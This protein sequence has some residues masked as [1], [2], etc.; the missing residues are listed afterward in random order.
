VSSP[1]RLVALSEL[2]VLQPAAADQPP[3]A[4][5]QADHSFAEAAAPAPTPEPEPETAAGA[6]DVCFSSPAGN[7]AAS[8]PNAFLGFFQF[9]FLSS[10]SFLGLTISCVPVSPSCSISRAVGRWLGCRRGRGSVVSVEVRAPFG[11]YCPTA[12]RRRS[13]RG[14][15]PGDLPGLQAPV[16][17]DALGPVQA[18]LLLRDLPL[19]PG[20][21]DILLHLRRRSPFVDK[22][23]MELIRLLEGVICIYIRYGVVH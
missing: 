2:I 15:A 12:P 23:S 13:V 6:H 20:R 16:C 3:A 19:Q 8:V 14:G 7:V 22:E 9:R 21:Q 4:V 18:R 5:P 11:T 17:G 10:S 1:W